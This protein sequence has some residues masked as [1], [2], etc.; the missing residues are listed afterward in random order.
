MKKFS[1]NLL[2][3]VFLLLV[4]FCSSGESGGTPLRSGVAAVAEDDGVQKVK[5]GTSLR[6]AGTALKVPRVLKKKKKRPKAAKSKKAKSAV[7][8]TPQPSSPGSTNAVTTPQPSSQPTNGP[9]CAV[10]TNQKDALLALAAGFTNGD[11]V[12]ADWDSSTDPCTDTWTGITC[13]G[14]D[15]TEISLAAA[16]I[17][18]TIS[19][20]F[21]GCPTTLA[22]T[23]TF[24][25]FFGNSLTGSI[26]TEIGSLSSLTELSFSAN[27]LTG[28]IPTEIGSLSSL[29]KL[30]VYT[31]S[32]SGLIPTEI[33]SLTSLTYL[34]FYINSLSGSIPTEIGSL[35][36][37]TQLSFSV[38]SLTGSI[39]TEIGSLTSLTELYFTGNSLSG[40]I[41][42]EIGSLSSLTTL[43]FISNDLSGAMPTSICALNSGGMTLVYDTAKVTPGCS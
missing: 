34:G 41:P 31:N 22:A 24:L 36:G 9:P 33:G 4:S 30:S 13:D 38:N 42:S 27:S 19:P 26:P 17:S 14:S 16:S 20:L 1:F 3:F 6:R 21:A 10:I 43:Y 15:V 40:S 35:T 7:L 37:L 28:S 18:G 11:T 5:G 39:P 23:L 12:L 29:T 2:V 8:T 32:L 25:N